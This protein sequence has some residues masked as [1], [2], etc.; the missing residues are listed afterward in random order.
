[1]GMGMGMGMGMRMG[2]RMGMGVGMGMGMGM[3]MWDG[4]G[5]GIGTTE[6]AYR[7]GVLISEVSAREYFGTTML[8]F[9]VVQIHHK[10]GIPMTQEMVM[11]MVMVMVIEM[12]RYLLC[13][14]CLCA[15]VIS[16]ASKCGA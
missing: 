5:D 16:I 6:N 7:S 1:M 2:M 14:R 12:V 11:V 3:E 15:V 9:D 13:G 8:L 4:D 10:S